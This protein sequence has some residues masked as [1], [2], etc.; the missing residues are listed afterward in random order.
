MADD[1]IKEMVPLFNEV[2]TSKT[3]EV[4]VF[5]SSLLDK[6]KEVKQ[7]KE[8]LA[9]LLERYNKEKLIKKLLNKVTML[10]D[11]GIIYNTNSTSEV[12]VLLKVIPKLDM[13]RLKNQYDQI[14]SLLNKRF[15][16]I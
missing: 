12:I 13:K 2:T 6:K 10:V 9:G 3:S 1:I 8:K 15:S 5:E 11:S 16:R 14:T 7:K 4:R